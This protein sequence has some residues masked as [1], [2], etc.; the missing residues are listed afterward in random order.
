MLD[1]E[2]CLIWGFGMQFDY[3]NDKKTEFKGNFI[4]Y[5]LKRPNSKKKTPFMA[6][7]PRGKTLIGVLTSSKAIVD[8]FRK[9]SSDIRKVFTI[10]DN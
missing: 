7:V 9:N 1:K 10:N 5:S 2:L 8:R 6:V 4:M 3:T